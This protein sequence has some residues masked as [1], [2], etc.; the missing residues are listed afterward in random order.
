MTE[1]MK[2]VKD[3]IRKTFRTDEEL[4]CFDG[5]TL[6]IEEHCA[7]IR[8]ACV[9]EMNQ[10]FEEIKDVLDIIGRDVKAIKR[11]IGLN[12]DNTR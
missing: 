9:L 6:Y 8:N 1:K 4:N 12:G 11:D 10:K 5:C 2:H 3:M 7:G